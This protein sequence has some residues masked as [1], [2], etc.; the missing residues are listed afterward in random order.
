MSEA[1]IK[2]I[3]P[4]EHLSIPLPAGGGVTVLL[5][6]NDIGKSETLRAIK[7]A[8]GADER[9]TKR[10]GTLRGEVDLLGV[11]LSV[12]ASARETGEAEF[13]SLEG[14]L[15]V[16]DLVDPQLKDPAA[17]DRRRIQALLTI[18]G[19]KA[20]PAMFYDLVGGKD[21][22]EALVKADTLR[23]T[24]LVDM[25]AKVRR[26]FHE[27]ARAAQDGATKEEGRIAACREQLAG[28]DLSAECDEAVLQEA[29]CQTV[30]RASVLDVRSD[31]AWEAS[32]KAEVA[33]KQLDAAQASYHGLSVEEASSQVL[34]RQEDW[35]AARGRL[36][37]AEDALRQAKRAFEDCTRAVRDAEAQ[38]RSAIEHQA[39]MDGWSKTI[40]EGANVE[41]PTTEAL[42]E[43]HAA[44]HLA[45]VAVERGAEVRKAK[46]TQ[47]R[48]ER[49]IDLAKASLAKADQL[50][51]AARSTDDVLSH[52]VQSKAI[53]V[54]SDDRGNP[55]LVTDHPDRGETYYADRSRGTRWKIALDEAIERVR[56]IGGE[57]RALIPIPQEAWEGLDD[58]NRQEID[59][60][61]RTL[62]V[63]IITAEAVDGPLRSMVY[64]ED[65][66]ATH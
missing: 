27:A 54:Q 34:L 23:A 22:F 31:T 14:R 44:V 45:R 65:A 8:A 33:R 57:G 32:K 46:E 17:A 28:V 60:H 64:G 39:A 9:L 47:A 15:D 18:R 62:G 43:A 36:Q 16:S 20:D 55:R 56:E 29:L 5:G 1:T 30:K 38:Q 59:Q 40:E 51:T 61:A 11:R 41:T 48:L 66:N 26:D 35:E 2:N 37:D 10:D 24:D 4:V 52:A 53:R 42:E 19:V 7:R 21:A 6:S 58:A 49:H 50:R 63:N 13:S 25:A 12:A 3:G